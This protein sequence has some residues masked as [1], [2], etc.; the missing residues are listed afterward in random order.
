MKSPKPMGSQQINEHARHTKKKT[1]PTLKTVH[2]DN[3]KWCGS[4]R[5]SWGIIDD[6]LNVV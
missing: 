4:K 1:T 3:L 5:V 6:Y 2:G